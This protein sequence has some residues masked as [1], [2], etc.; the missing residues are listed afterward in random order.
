[1]YI[2]LTNRCSNDCDFC[3]RNFKNGLGNDGGLWLEYEPTADETIEQLQKKMDIYKN[4]KEI[5]FC[6]YGEPTYRLKEILSIAKFVKDKY[7]GKRVRL[8]TNGLGNIINKKKI[9]RDLSQVLDS[10]SISL[11]APTKHKYDKI[12][13]P[14]FGLE[15]FDYILSFIKDCVAINLDTTLSVVDTL[16]SNKIE[17]SRQ[18]TQNLGAKFRIRKTSDY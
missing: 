16:D 1:M 11:N 18:L 14:I 13:K 5:V 9:A 3:I 15:S 10:V 6:G 12:C 17:Q 2:N 7:K 4:V 8:N